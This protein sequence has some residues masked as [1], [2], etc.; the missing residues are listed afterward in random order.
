MFRKPQSLNQPFKQ[1]R[2]RLRQVNE[3]YLP[4]PS[5][6]KRSDAGKD[7]RSPVPEGQEGDASNGRG[8]MKKLR[9]ML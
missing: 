1:L 6:N 4:L 8:Q 7:I 3:A 5:A 2:R 9:Q